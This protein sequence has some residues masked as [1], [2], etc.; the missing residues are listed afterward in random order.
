MPM[1]FRILKDI[2]SQYRNEEGKGGRRRGA[3]ADL[4][5]QLQSA[6]RSANGARQFAR[7]KQVLDV[8]G[9]GSVKQLVAFHTRQQKKE[10]DVDKLNEAVISL[11]QWLHRQNASLSPEGTIIWSKSERV[12]VYDRDLAQQNL[13][14]LKIQNQ[15]LY[16]SDLKPFDT[17][18][19]VTHFSGP[20][21]AIYVMSK[22][23]NLHVD[24]HSVGHRHHSSLLAGGR[25][26]CAGEM[27]VKQGQLKLLTNKSGHYAPT[28]QH[29]LEVLAA[30]DLQGVPLNFQIE[31]I[32][33]KKYL[34]AEAFLKANNFDNQTLDSIKIL[35]V[36]LKTLQR[37]GED[38]LE[39]LG[40]AWEQ[41]RGGP[42]HLT[43]GH[44]Y[45]AATRRRL[46]Y[47]EL[48]AFLNRNHVSCL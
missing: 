13:T 38:V 26:A 42:N 11:R 3:L 14:R 15:M 23:G 22:E 4:E 21:Y 33:D 34:N 44:L 35:V 10:V 5:G 30:L 40:L 39:E 45:D 29:L 48:T 12:V 25:V 19:M 37:Y 6:I 27:V 43:L 24:S 28:P 9:P 16:T 18:K 20:G 41:P 1:E 32:G 47:D 36:W 7:E 31:C 8:R 46:N 17:T 2:Q